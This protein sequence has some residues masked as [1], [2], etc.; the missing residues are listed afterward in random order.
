MTEP[1]A[2]YRQA[3]RARH[4]AAAMDRIAD[5]FAAGGLTDLPDVFLIIIERALARDLT[6]IVEFARHPGDPA[7]PT[8]LETAP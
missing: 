3:V 5:R 8:P 2:D 7:L 6:G 1:L 4:R